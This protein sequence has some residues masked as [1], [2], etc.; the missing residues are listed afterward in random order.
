MTLTNKEIVEM[1]RRHQRL[2]ER[3]ET[4]A[5]ELRRRRHPL[6]SNAHLM[7]EVAEVIEWLQEQNA[8]L[9]KEVNDAIR[10]GS[11]AAREAYTEGRLDATESG[12][13]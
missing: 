8:A 4:I 12:N 2:S 9:R 6:S 7:L 13:Q 10:E 3:S 11:L 1:Q 5:D